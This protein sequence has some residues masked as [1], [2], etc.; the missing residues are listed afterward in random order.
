M[1]S[2]GNAV[3]GGVWETDYGSGDFLLGEAAGPGTVQGGRGVDGDRVAG[4]THAYEAW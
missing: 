3:G 2:G 1:I 4:G